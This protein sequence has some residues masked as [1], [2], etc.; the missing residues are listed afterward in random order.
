MGVESEEARNFYINEAIDGNWSTRQLEREINTFSYQRY[1]ASHGNH[2]VVEDV[3]KRELP[4]EPQSIIKD[5]YV[6][7]FLGLKPDSAFLKNKGINN[8][9]VIMGISAKSGTRK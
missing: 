5:P 3:T 1:L 6:L 7:N 4:S 9:A 8:A 2:D